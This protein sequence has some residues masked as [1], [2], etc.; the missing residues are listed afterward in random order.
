MVN[1]VHVRL[2][3]P[4]FIDRVSVSFGYW[5]VICSSGLRFSNS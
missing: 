1:L 3:A 5:G 4:Y 2:K